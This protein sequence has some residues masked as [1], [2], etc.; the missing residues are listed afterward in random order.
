MTDDAFS[1]GTQAPLDCIPPGYKVRV[2]GDDDAGALVR[3]HLEAFPHFFLSR[4]GP[5]FLRKYYSALLLHRAGIVLLAEDRYEPCGFAAGSSDP[6][7]FYSE[8]RRRRL[9]LALCAVPALVRMPSLIRRLLIDAERVSVESI[10]GGDSV[11]ELASLAVGRAARRHGLGTQLVRAFAAK[12][13]ERHCAGVTVRTDALGNDSVVEF[14]KRLGFVCVR[15]DH[16]D[17]RRPMLELRLTVVASPV[18]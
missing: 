14:Y 15:S 9:E 8:I 10:A 12:A 7:D 4:L 11:C 3:L 18:C 13:A 5:A 2:A 1:P 16:S 17:R 6:A